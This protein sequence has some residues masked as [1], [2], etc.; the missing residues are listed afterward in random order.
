MLVA[1]VRN[2]LLARMCPCL[3]LGHGQSLLL[4]ASAAGS[5]SDWVPIILGEDDWVPSGLPLPACGC[6]ACWLTTT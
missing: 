2:R 4:L 3:E 1:A 6:A 5:G